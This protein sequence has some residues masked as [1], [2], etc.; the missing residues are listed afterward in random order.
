MKIASEIGWGHKAGGARRVAIRVLQELEKSHPNDEFIT[1][2]NTRF[3]DLDSLSIKQEVI[4]TPSF[5][6]QTI[7]NQFVFP[8]IV[9]P[10]RNRRYRPDI[11]HYTNNIVSY[12]LGKIPAVVT[13]HDMT[14]FVISETFRHAH[15]A[16]Q[17]A[18]FRYAAKHAA[19]IITVSQ[20]SSEDIC[21]LLNVP[22]KK[23][24][25]A[26]LAVDNDY[27]VIH[28]K[29]TSALLFEKIGVK[30]PFILYV[31]A[32]HPRKNLA[33]LIN[34]FAK[35]KETKGIPHK[36]VV[37][38]TFRWLSKKVLTDSQFKR[39][40]TDVVFAD[41]LSDSELACLYSAC[42]LFVWPSLY[43]GFG[44]PILEAMTCGAPVVT[45]NCSSMPE[46]AGDAA[47]LVDPSSEQ[48]I[49]DAMWRVIDDKEL[50]RK[51]RVLGKKRAQQFSWEKTAE[52][53]YKVY[54]SL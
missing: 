34:A 8:H 4:P 36:L 11:I 41:G 50:A 40:E 51:L 32:V 48:E 22:E 24:I 28:N 54:Q 43:E 38:G 2:S 17:R 30:G 12:P 1:Y 20:H 47:L 6:P 15:G 42:D 37:A 46:V 31:G 21:R 16:Y 25:V 29:K 26:P 53:V 3:N 39:V 23:I 19:K 13:I 52:K 44:L 35:L 10:L 9:V 7:W 45:S 33:R 18:Y 5:C 27:H 14:P 49:S